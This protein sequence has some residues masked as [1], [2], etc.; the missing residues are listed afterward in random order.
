MSALMSN[1][2]MI[3]STRLQQKQQRERRDHS[4]KSI[5]IKFGRRDG[6]AKR[7]SKIGKGK[8]A[9]VT[10]LR[11]LKTALNRKVENLYTYQWIGLILECHRNPSLRI[12]RRNKEAAE[13][14]YES[15]QRRVDDNVAD[16]NRDGQQLTFKELRQ[17]L[18]IH[19]DM[20]NKTLRR[21]MEITRLNPNDGDPLAEEN[22]A[23]RP[24]SGRPRQRGIKQDQPA[25][26]SQRILVRNYFQEGIGSRAT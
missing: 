24:R 12:F 8:Q 16:K 26:H 1:V 9:A 10:I 13:M 11:K 4:S 15:Y 14:S 23:S 22:L 7:D 18:D 21:T 3:P 17:L 25:K 6:N 5:S 19:P 20:I 2:G